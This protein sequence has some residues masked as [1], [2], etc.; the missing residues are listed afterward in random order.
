M[1]TLRHEALRELVPV[2][3]L[4]RSQI[5]LTINPAVLGLADLPSW[6]VTFPLPARKPFREV[7][8]RIDGPV[9]DAT[10]DEHLMGLLADAREAQAL[11]AVNPGLSLNKIAVQHGRCRK[12]L[13]KLY[14][15]SWISPRIVEAIAGG[16]QPKALTR[17]RLLEA[18]LPIAWADQEALLGLTA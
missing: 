14:R 18:A 17:S 6:S 3:R 13:V 12:Q 9:S 10:I 11:V 15:L 7:K 4:G 16:G 2:I 8:L 5:E 1:S